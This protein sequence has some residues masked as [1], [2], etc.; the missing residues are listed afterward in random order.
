M[1]YIPKI[2]K[3]ILKSRPDLSSDLIHLT[4]EYDGHQAKDN[5]ISILNSG[6]IEARNV[7]FYLHK[8]LPSEWSSDFK[9]LSLTETP[10]NQIKNIININ[11]KRKIRLEPFGLVFLKSDLLKVGAAP[12]QYLYQE[13]QRAF[14]RELFQRYIEDEKIY[15]GIH[16]F[17]FLKGIHERED[18][19]WERE[20]KKRGDL[21]LDTLKFVVLV[22]SVEVAEEVYKAVYLEQRKEMSFFTLDDE[23]SGNILFQEDI[24]ENIPEYGM[25]DNVKLVTGA[26]I[27]QWELFEDGDPQVCFYKII[28]VSSKIMKSK[29]YLTE[30]WGE[31]TVKAFYE[32]R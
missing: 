16:V 28:E 24:P 23:R 2:I 4:R 19:H 14:Y 11:F 3:E 12:V 29:D 32:G 22:P 15:E 21:K 13:N 20:W 6:T 17:P 1:N 18:F 31:E 9:V 30:Q 25:V 27:T 8:D 5:L 7:D 10:L 26:E